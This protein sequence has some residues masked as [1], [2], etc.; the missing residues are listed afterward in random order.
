MKAE[1]EIDTSRPKAMADVL[2]PSLRT[3]DKVGYQIK[4]DSDFSI[5]IKTDTLGR[6]RGATDT[7]LMLAMLA[8]KTMLR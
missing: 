3:D 2:R 4:D 6:M 1:L 8:Q 7:C 5:Q